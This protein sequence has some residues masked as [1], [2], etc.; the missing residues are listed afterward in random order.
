MGKY[1]ILLLLLL[2]LVKSSK[3]IHF[4]SPLHSLTFLPKDF[5]KSAS[6]RRDAF[7][8]KLNAILGAEKV[9]R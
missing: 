2:C 5:K 6:T 1:S 3:T 4:L 9:A 7:L 8:P